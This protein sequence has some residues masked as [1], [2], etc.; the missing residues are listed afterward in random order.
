MEQLALVIALLVLCIMACMATEEW[1]PE[2]Y[3]DPQKDP[4]ACGRGNVKSFVCDPNGLIP[5]EDGKYLSCKCMQLRN[6]TNRTYIMY[7]IVYSWVFSFVCCIG[8]F[9]WDQ[10]GCV[11]FM[12]HWVWCFLVGM[13]FRQQA[14]IYTKQASR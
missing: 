11:I 12:T 1:S 6:C 4:G 13:P 10:P 8:T 7:V 14:K 5:S 2:E 3:P 9:H